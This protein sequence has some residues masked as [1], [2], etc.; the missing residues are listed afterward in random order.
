MSIRFSFGGGRS[1][2][3]PLLL[4]AI[5]VFLYLVPDLQ[6][7]LQ[8][9]RGAIRGGEIWRLVTGH[10]THTSFDHLVLDVVTFLALA[11]I[12]DRLDRLAFHRTIAAGLVLI[13]GALWIFQ[14]SLATYRGLSGLDSALF[15][16]A[17]LLLYRD[18]KSDPETWA[19]WPAG[20]A[21]L[22]FSTKVAFEMVT[23]HALFVQST[24]AMTVV[25]L[26]HLAGALSGFV[27]VALGREERF[28]RACTTRCS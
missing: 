18:A 5:A 21:L 28:D 23:G 17:T 7:V 14:P 22:L 24:E 25:P 16:L 4:S 26:A 9:D 15:V 8:Y 13:P 1:R 11:M 3:V 20:L 6:E 2:A 12:C 27:A 10:W 19:H